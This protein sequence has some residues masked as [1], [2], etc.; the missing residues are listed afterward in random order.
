MLVNPA[1]EDTVYE[2]RVTSDLTVPRP[3][4]WRGDELG[5]TPPEA[6]GSLG[7]RRSG[8]GRLLVRFRE[9]PVPGGSGSRER[10][11]PLEPRQP[12]PRSQFLHIVKRRRRNLQGRSL[13]S[14]K[15]S[16]VGM[17]Y[18]F[19]TFRTGAHDLFEST[20]PQEV[21]TVKSTFSS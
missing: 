16:F 19:P 9:P 8:A 18:K 10:V 13:S 1:L 5:L 3:R 17:I 14:W 20:L 12:M 4:L 21:G 6:G 11:W 2:C 7:P 15:V